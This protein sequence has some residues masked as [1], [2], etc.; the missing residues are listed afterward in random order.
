MYVKINENTFFFFFLLSVYNVC[1]QHSTCHNY[2]TQKIPVLAY[3]AHLSNFYSQV[4]SIVSVFSIQ[5]LSQENYKLDREVVSIVE[6]SNHHH[7]HHT[8]YLTG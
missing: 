4:C 2:E 8:L 1:T 3:F 6:Y 5:L 7:H